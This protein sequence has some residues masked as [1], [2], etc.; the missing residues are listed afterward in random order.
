MLTPEEIELCEE[1]AANSEVV[2]KLLQE[3]LI[4][5]NSDVCET[6]LAIKNKQS[7][8]NRTLQEDIDNPDLKDADKKFE[9]ELKMV[10]E[11]DNIHSVLDKL[12]ARMTDE[13][14]EG[15]ENKVKSSGKNSK[16]NS[17]RIT[18]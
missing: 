11:A 13:E 17:K 7:V 5:V 9:R 1:F 18:V 3:Y 6:F 16:I 10:L 14:K 12:L 8:W 15:I 2:A 4:F